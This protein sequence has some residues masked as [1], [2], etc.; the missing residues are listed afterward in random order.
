MLVKL[1]KYTYLVLAIGILVVAAIIENGLLRRNPETKLIDDF[2]A[3][4]LVNESTLHDKL[5]EIRA[6]LLEDDLEDNISEFFS[7]EETLIRQTGF[8]AMVFKNNELFFWSDRGITFYDRLEDIPKTSGLAILPNGYYLVDTVNV[9]EYTAVAY[10]LVKRNYTYENKYL[11]NN[12]YSSYKLP[13]D[14]IIRTEKY[15]H[16]Y[17]IVNL[18]GEYL[19]TLLPYGNYLCTTNQLYFPEQFI[20]SDLSCCCF[21]SGR[22]LWIMM[23]RFS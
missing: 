13:S 10:H 20:L 4:L 17:D 3:Q 14:Y 18:K 16:G 11:Q 5:A 21:I 15:K 2:Q 9:G 6:I 7:R 19:F 22:N 8:G 1:N 12:F 23:R